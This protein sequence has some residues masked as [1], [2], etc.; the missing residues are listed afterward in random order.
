MSR[1]DSRRSSCWQCK[2]LHLKRQLRDTADLDVQNCLMALTGVG[3]G[4][5]VMAGEWYG[6]GERRLYVVVVVWH[7]VTISAVS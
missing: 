6:H 3:V 2:R 5:M 4:F 1:V 7:W